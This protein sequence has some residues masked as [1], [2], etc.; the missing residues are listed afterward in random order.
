MFHRLL[1]ASDPIVSLNR[2]FKAKKRAKSCMTK[3]MT[4]KMLSLLKPQMLYESG[5]D[6][7][8]TDSEIDLSDLSSSE[9]EEH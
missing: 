8:D 1:L 5:S 9:F 7:S 4:E 2:D 6:A 3:E